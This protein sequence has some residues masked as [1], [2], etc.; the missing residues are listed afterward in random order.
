MFFFRKKST[1]LWAVSVGMEKIG[2]LQA[3]N[4]KFLRCNKKKK[5]C[6]EILHSCNFVAFW[7]EEKIY[8]A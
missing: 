7:L 1:F 5:M 2:K 6:K 3:N 8:D 4:D